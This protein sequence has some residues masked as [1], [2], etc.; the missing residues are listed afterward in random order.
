[1]IGQTRSSND[2]AAGSIRCGPKACFFNSG[3]F[4]YPQVSGFCPQPVCSGCD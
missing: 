3:G 2:H 1:V 4:R